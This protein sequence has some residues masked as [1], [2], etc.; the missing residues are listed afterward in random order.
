MKG[1]EKSSEKE[2]MLEEIEL[3]EKMKYF[4]GEGKETKDPGKAVKIVV[5]VLDSQGNLL[6]E[7]ILNKSEV[8]H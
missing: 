2:F 8:S 1:M 6:E 3:P 4:D 7:S 5:Q